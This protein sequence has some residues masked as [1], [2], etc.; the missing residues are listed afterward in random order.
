MHILTRDER[1]LALQ[2]LQTV[3]PK[4]ALE[5]PRN[6]WSKEDEI[7]LMSKFDRDYEE[8]RKNLPGAIFIE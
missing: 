7:H 2:A 4:T 1:V 8:L 5:E 6:Y 3:F